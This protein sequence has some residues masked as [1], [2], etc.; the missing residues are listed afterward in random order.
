MATRIT[1]RASQ[2]RADAQVLPG[3]HNSDQNQAC[4]M[5]MGF[6]SDDSVAGVPDTPPVLFCTRRQTR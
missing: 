5:G 3:Q 2:Q 1:G 6:L 4:R